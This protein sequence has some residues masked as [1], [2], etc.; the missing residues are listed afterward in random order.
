MSKLPQQKP[1]VRKNP[2]KAKKQE[3]KPTY[4]PPKT[5]DLAEIEQGQG[6]LPICTGGSSPFVGCAVGNFPT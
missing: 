4:E 1:V 6:G 3:N 2:K 5:V